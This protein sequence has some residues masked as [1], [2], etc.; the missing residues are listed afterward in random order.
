MIQI[1]NLSF[2]Y[3]KNSKRI[4]DDI[5]FEIQQGSVNV[6]LGLNGCGK[7][8]LIKLMAGLLIPYLG[9]ILYV[10]DSISLSGETEEGD[11]SGITWSVNNS[12]VASI[13]G[14]TLT[15]LTPGDLTITATHNEFTESYSCK[16]EYRKPESLKIDVKS[17]SIYM[18]ETLD[19]RAILTPANAYDEIVWS[20]NDD[21]QNWECVEFDG[22][23]IKAIKY[24]KVYISAQSKINYNARDSIVVEVLHPLVDKDVYEAKYIAFGIKIKE[25][26]NATPV[27]AYVNV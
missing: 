23:S 15:L 5:S 25:S 3:Y 26:E 4:L 6:L 2:Q 9:E 8:T 24:G 14:N 10:N 27:L 1:K 11:N 16:V 17:Y 22:T 13:N 12:S 19:L 21:Q 7:T 18:G 20:I